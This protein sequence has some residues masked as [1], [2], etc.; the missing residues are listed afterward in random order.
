MLRHGLLSSSPRACW[1]WQ[2]AV[3][4]P[5]W[6]PSWPFPSCRQRGTAF[7]TLGASWPANQ[8]DI[9]V[10]VTLFWLRLYLNKVIDS[11]CFFILIKCKQRTMS[12]V[13]IWNLHLIEDSR[14]NS[15]CV[16]CILFPVL[17]SSGNIKER[18]WTGGLYIQ[19]TKNTKKLGLMYHFSQT[20]RKNDLAIRRCN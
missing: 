11:L 1:T 14:K 16:K 2:T 19:Q 3:I 7:R 17:P 10:T 15:Q 5:L 9:C 12:S 6:K 4:S 20:R 13:S 18:H 8:V